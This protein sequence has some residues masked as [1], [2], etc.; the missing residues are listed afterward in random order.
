MVGERDTATSTDGLAWLRGL[1]RTLFYIALPL[2]IV[3]TAVRVLFSEQAVYNYAIEHYHADQATGIA[4]P[5][6]LAATR[7]IRAYFSDSQ[8]YL[9][10]L[11][12]D[13]NGQVVPLFNSREVLHMHDVKQ[14][15]RFFDG[16]Q[17]WS[18][19]VV[20]AY[21]IGV[22]L[23]AGEESLAA[24]ARRTVQAVLGT[25][26]ALALFGLIAVTGGF[27]AA[28]IK[29]HEL[30]F[31]NDYWQLDPSRDH[32]VQ[33]FPEGFWLFATL[34][35]CALIVVQCLAYGGGAWLYLRSHRP[36]HLE[37]ERD[38]ARKTASES[39]I[40]EQRTPARTT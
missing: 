34:L 36:V 11:V 25:I 39:P 32:L 29:F 40:E 35:L 3:S 17:G 33:M 28:F 7:D 19:L 8:D 5:D 6:L 14:V 18:L 1:A 27:D 13:Q 21:I 22:V 16:V 37:G 15:V 4:Q 2:L 10:T 12:H 24:L 38:A 23:W 30:V 31:H 9:R 26:A 20:A